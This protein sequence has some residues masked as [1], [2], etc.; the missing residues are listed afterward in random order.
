MINPVLKTA[1]LNLKTD[2]DNSCINKIVMNNIMKQWRDQCLL[3][4]GTSRD[5]LE[6]A[7][8][9]HRWNLYSWK[10]GYCRFFR[11]QWWGAGHR[12]V[13]YLSQTTRWLGSH[14]RSMDGARQT[15]S[16]LP[17]YSPQKTGRTWLDNWWFLQFA[18]GLSC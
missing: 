11:C 5:F 13:L 3:E 15:S 12:R 6:M 18:A 2:Q 16:G 4:E 1:S 10:N 17:I 14:R 8:Q 7:I 9:A